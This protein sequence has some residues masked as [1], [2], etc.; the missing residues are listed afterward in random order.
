MFV[1]GMVKIVEF[2]SF[3]FKLKVSDYRKV[4]EKGTKVSYENS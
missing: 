4:K 2:T 3:D 1:L